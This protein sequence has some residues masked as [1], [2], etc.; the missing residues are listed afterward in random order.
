M[1]NGPT[2]GAIAA[3]S[4]LILQLVNMGSSSVGNGNVVTAPG[5]T[6]Q[7]PGGAQAGPA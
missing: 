5:D 4:N 7:V 2:S 1:I 6:G 3:V